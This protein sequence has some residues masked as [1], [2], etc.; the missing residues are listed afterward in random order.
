[1]KSITGERANSCLTPLGLE[2]GSWNQLTDKHEAERKNRAWI[3]HRAP[4]DALEMRCFA[5]HAAGWVPKGAWKI[6]QIDN[7]TSLTRSE[8]SFFKGV[9]S[10]AQGAVDQMRPGAFLFEFGDDE[11]VNADTEL[12]L[13]NIVFGFLLFECHGYVVSSGSVGGEMLGIQ[14][15]FAYFS[16]RDGG[17]ASDA[18]VLVDAFERNRLASPKWVQEINART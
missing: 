12:L 6:F 18:K 1:M 17:G 4:R 14:D 13:S 5:E 11:E 16:S 2:I 10:C 8:V 9:I 15:G 7:S 3:K